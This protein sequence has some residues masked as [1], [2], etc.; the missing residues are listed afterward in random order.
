MKT[1]ETLPLREALRVL[2]RRLGVLEKTEAA[3][4]Q[5]SL[6]Q[7]HALTEVGRAGAMSLGELS[8]LLMLEKS[9]LSRTVNQLVEDGLLT[10]DADSA[11]R[12]YVAISL[13]D[14]GEKVYEQNEESMLSY[15]GGVLEKIPADKRTQVLESLTLLN[16]ALSE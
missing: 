4:C 16:E 1:Y 15:Y 3:C 5:M 6:T 10:R 9:T 14:A 8:D 12:R 7:C 13:S 11:D 2:V